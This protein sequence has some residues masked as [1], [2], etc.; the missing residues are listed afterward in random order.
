[1]SSPRSMMIDAD[2]EPLPV[3]AVHGISPGSADVAGYGAELAASMLRVG[4]K[5]PRVIEAAWADLAGHVRGFAPLARV[6][7]GALRASVDAVTQVVAYD[8]VDSYRARI[9]RRVESVVDRHPGCVLLGHSLGSV[10]CLDLIIDWISTGK[11]DLRADRSSWPIS[12]LVT[13][14]SPLGIDVPLLPGHGF[15]DRSERLERLSSV[16][17][18]TQTAAWSWVNLRDPDDPVTSGDVFGRPET[19]VPLNAHAGYARLG[20]IDYVVNTGVHLHAHTNYWSNDAVARA[21]AALVR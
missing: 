3:V 16:W 10:V 4:V 12:G 5:R 13:M 20:V 18:T 9:M 1:M 17:R 6:V 14:G 21:V 19:S 8:Y 2:A 7:A 11:M 15:V